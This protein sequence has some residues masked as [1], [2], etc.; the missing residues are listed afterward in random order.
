MEQTW[1]RLTFLH[2]SYD[3]AVV[4]AQLP[5][6]LRVE[7]FD[8]RAWVGLVPFFMHVRLPHGRD[9]GRLTCFPET[10]VRTYA[11][12]AD[13]NHGVWFLSLDATNLPAVLCG[14]GGYAVPYHWSQMQVQTLGD[15][16][17]YSCRRRWPGP[18]PARSEV[19]VRIGELYAPGELTDFDHWL[20]A[21]FRLFAN[22][23]DRG[24]RYALAEHDVWPLHRAE[25]LHVDDTLVTAA[26]L[27]APVGDPVVH[28]S[29]GVDVRIG[30]PHRLVSP[31]APVQ[32]SADGNPRD[33]PRP[34]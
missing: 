5:D 19:A 27:P 15:I 28:W 24:L 14:R 18:C 29:P 32:C 30:L 17:A 20:T 31:T 7:T 6:G 25:V 33:L 10:N 13:G 2:W 16:A 11:V 3:P 8:D 34:P 1:A 23:W 12:D 9:L 4:Q 22:P 26:G 21:R